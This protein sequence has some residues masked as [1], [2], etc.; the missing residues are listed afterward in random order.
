MWPFSKKKEEQVEYVTRPEYISEPIISFVSLV[1]D[2]PKRFSVKLKDE[3]P[4]HGHN[5]TIWELRDKKTGEVFT[6]SVTTPRGYSYFPALCSTGSLP[7]V[8]S[9][10]WKYLYKEITLVKN[11]QKEKVLAYK[12]DKARKRYMKIYGPKENVNV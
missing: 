11:A 10:E 8:T 12:N 6:A 2:N 9:D 1:R 7:W 5:T 4:Y 3:R